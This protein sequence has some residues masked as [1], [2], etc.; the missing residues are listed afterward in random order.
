MC[1]IEQV[2]LLDI[3]PIVVI[4]VELSVGIDLFLRYVLLVLIILQ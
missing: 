3:A 2:L 1:F 4:S